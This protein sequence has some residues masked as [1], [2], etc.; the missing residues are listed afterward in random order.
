MLPDGIRSVYA[1]GECEID[2]ARRELRVRGSPVPLGA[3]AFEIIEVLAQSA[4]ELVTKDELMN[5]IWPGAVVM[6]NTLQVHAVA[7][8]KALGPHRDMLKTE[9]RRGYRLLGEWTVRRHDAAKPP[10]GLQQVRVDGFAPVTNFPAAV[11]RLVGRS[12]AVARLR[13]LISAYRVVTL[14][15]PGGI[16]KTTL[17]IAATRGVVADFDDGGWFVELA[18]LSS[19]DL[20]PSTV[21]SALGLKLGGEISAES[22]ARAIG[23]KRLLLVLDSCEHVIDAAANLAERLIRLCPRIGI[24]LTSREMLRIDGEVVYRVPPLDVPALGQETPDH[25]L[26]Q[27]A[28]ELFIAR[29]DA[30]GVG[31]SPR[32]EELTSVA[33]ICR[34]LDGIPLAIEFAA[35]S[36]ALLGI[37]SV[38]TGLGDRFALL[39]RGRRTALPKDRTLR[40]TI[41]WSYELLPETEQRLLRWLAVFQSAFT[42]DD[43]VAF[44]VETSLDAATVMHGIAGLVSKSLIALDKALGV[45]RWYLL[46]TIRAYSLRKL[47]EHGETMS[48]QRRHARY[49][50]DLF[51]RQLSADR[52]SRENLASHIQHIDDVRTALDWCFSLSGDVTTGVELTAAFAQ[53]WI[54]LSLGAECRDRCERALMHC[55]SEMEPSPEQRMRLLTGLGSTLVLT[56]GPAEQAVTALTHA[57]E[58]AERLQDLD[59]QARIN[60]ALYSALDS[61]GERGKTCIIAE[62]L[63]TTG[64]QL[65]DPTIVAV[66]C[67]LAGLSLLRTDGNPRDAQKMLERGLNHLDEASD[68]RQTVWSRSENRAGIR[69]L[70]S[71]SLCMQGLLETA[72]KEASASLDGLDSDI[73]RLSFCR[74]LVMGTCRVALLT[75]DFI[76]ADWAIERVKKGTTR[77]NAIIWEIDGKFLEAA[78]MVARGD[79]AEGL[80]LLN[81]TRDFCRRVGWKLLCAEFDCFLAEALAGLGRFSEALYVIEEALAFAGT[82][83]AQMLYVPELLRIKAEILLRHASAELAADCFRH[84]TEMASRQGALLWEL[85]IALSLARL[86][87]SQGRD[88]EARKVL[89]LVYDRFT[90]GFATTDLQATRTMIDRLPL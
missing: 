11:T 21:A 62:R 64:H 71:L 50:R 83:N 72:R 5:R 33:S 48:A 31:C 82:G 57:L 28:V 90:E 77:G 36:A 17:A 79:F 6:E 27:S 7:I 78:L 26:G 39:T 69:A 41:D 67:R 87:V 44:L 81:D 22:V 38:D 54:H 55:A 56:M 47:A 16:G 43:A 75:G 51:T 53:A 40:A 30:L 70:L 9:A 34:R 19:S 20:L 35:A 25:I 52:Q 73:H 42:L 8:R 58:I 60:W 37:A 68:Q 12:A 61:R 32:A 29:M 24:L 85:R 84:A 65:N 15:G 3:R 66:A 76:M 23:A 10:V 59:A 74:A 89:V 88:D 80:T 45:T 1:S 18:S 46:E 2:L 14:T 13:D 63:A 86:R 4:G 49:F